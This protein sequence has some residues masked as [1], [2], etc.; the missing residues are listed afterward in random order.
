MQEALFQIGICTISV[1]VAY[2][3]I[4]KFGFQ[5]VP[6]NNLSRFI[7]KEKKINESITKSTKGGFF[8]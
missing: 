4:K 6:S 3:V 7:K 5:K 1:P 8:S 2:F